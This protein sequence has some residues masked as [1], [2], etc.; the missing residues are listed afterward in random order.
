[1]KTLKM[2]FKNIKSV[3]SRDEM[4]KV[5]AG[6]NGG[7]CVSSGSNCS[8]CCPGADCI[9]LILGPDPDHPLAYGCS[10]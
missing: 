8:F 6:S 1:M 4:K 9:V 5:M 3:L 2:N 7:G 10:F